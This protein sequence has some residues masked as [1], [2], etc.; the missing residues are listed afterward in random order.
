MN[1]AQVNADITWM[2]KARQTL[3]LIRTDDEFRVFNATRTACFNAKYPVYDWTCKTGIMNMDVP[4]RQLANAQDP[5][6]ALDYIRD[7]KERAVYIMRD[8]QEWSDPVTRRALRNLA[9]DLQNSPFNEARTI[10]ILAPMSAKTLD[11]IPEMTTID[12]PLPDREEITSIM[13]LTL[14]S[15]QDDAIRAGAATNGS[16]ERSI[17]GGIGL[18]ALQVQ[19][20]YS[21]SLVKN[22]KIDPKLIT[23]EKKRLIAGISGVTWHEPDPRGLDAMGGYHD[24]KSWCTE[25]KV[26]FSQEARDFGLPAPK[27]LM[28]VG[29]P[30]GGKSL[31][32]KCV[33][34]LF[35]CP[36]LRLDLGALLS[37]FVGESQGN[38][39][40][41]LNLAET[42]SPC[43][44]WI[45]EL[46]K[47][48][49]GSTGAQGDG[50]VST[51]QLGTLLSWM[52]EKTASVFVV[53]TANDVRALPPELLRK[54]RFDEM[55]FVDLPQ[56][57]ERVE[58]VAATL[59]AFKRDPDTI[60]LTSIAEATDGFVG[61]EI[62]S[63]VPTA[64]RAAFIDGKREITT[65][66]LKLAASKVVPLA[67]TAS[68]K[69][70][71]LREWAKGRARPASAPEAVA[72]TSAVRSLDL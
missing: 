49:A 18:S 5:A 11:G 60:H 57:G 41:V 61:A 13:D 1:A 14:S 27:G 8:L 36:L 62:A 59:R 12:Y 22:R 25:C 2:L 35:Q 55:F 71:A 51:D 70:T 6:Q 37:K 68:E 32:A 65:E 28:L 44:L 17:D 53:A 47:G 67:K 69:I 10:V 23:A 19:N 38:I 45:D 42:M 50:G 20:S 64:M 39:R 33:A 4:P 34:T 3:I 63:L 7:R 30:G 21:L 48:L 54:G 66:D 31:L 9:Q 52:Q 24:L 29:L 16:R 72:A 46:E 56:Q 58:I 40:R 26:T 15:I 43:V